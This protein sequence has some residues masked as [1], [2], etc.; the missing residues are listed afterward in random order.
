MLQALCIKYSMRDLIS[1]VWLFVALLRHF[2]LLNLRCKKFVLYSSLL[3]RFK[4]TIWSY[5]LTFSDSKLEAQWY[6]LIMFCY[7][8]LHSNCDP[9]ILTV[10]QYDLLIT[11]KLLTFPWATLWMAYTVCKQPWYHNKFH[12]RL[13]Y[14]RHYA[15]RIGLFQKSISLNCCS[16]R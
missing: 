4:I 16:E 12:T 13:N 3:V 14:I 5:T 1:D 15:S 6:R 7:F 9:A 2:V 10:F 8:F 11:Q